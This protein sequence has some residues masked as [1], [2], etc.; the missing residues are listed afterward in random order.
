MGELVV[1]TENLVFSYAT[2][3]SAVPCIGPTSWEIPA[4]S[5]ALLMGETGSGKTTLLR[6]LTP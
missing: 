2:S 4:G 5:F 6:Q 3:Q 1:R